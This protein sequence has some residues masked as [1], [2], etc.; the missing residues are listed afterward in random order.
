M[1]SMPLYSATTTMISLLQGLIT[2]ALQVNSHRQK[3]PLDTPKMM[4]LQPMHFTTLQHG[5]I[6]HMPSANARKDFGRDHR[7][8][9]RARRKHPSQTISVAQWRCWSRKIRDRTEHC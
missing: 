4:Q 6:H 1:Q 7:S 5:L 8:D 3:A 9:S 2:S